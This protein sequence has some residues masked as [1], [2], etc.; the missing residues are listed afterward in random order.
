MNITEIRQKYPQ[1]NEI[2]DDE[3]AKKLH[4]K[5]YASMPFEEF[6][7]K[8]GLGTTAPTPPAP[9]VPSEQDSP[10]LGS[11]KSSYERMKGEGAL[12]A[13]KVGLMDEAEAEKYRA[14]QEKIAEQTYQP[15]TQG[16][17]EAPITKLK[18]LAGASLPYTAAP[19][20]AAGAAAL[21]PEAVIG[22]AGTA[23]IGGGASALQFTGTN[24]ARQM[25]ENKQTLHDTS[26]LKAGAAAVP[27]AALDIVGFK[28]MPLVRG[29]FGKAGIELSEQAAEEVAKRGILAQA[30]KYALNTG[31]VMGVEG[32]TEAG[33]QFFERLQ[34]GLSIAD[35]AA[36]QEYLESF[37]GGAALGG[38]FAVPGQAI[39]KVMA[40]KPE[41]KVPQKEI[42]PGKSMFD[43]QDEEDAGTVQPSVDTSFDVSALEEQK[44]KDTAKQ[45]F[46]DESR[47]AEEL[48]AATATTTLPETPTP[49]E[50]TQEQA[51]EE[52]R[53]YLFPMGAQTARDEAAQ[54]AYN[55]ANAELD[56]AIKSGNEADYNA[57]LDKVK[58]ARIEIDAVN[59]GKLGT[60]APLF[61]K[62][63]NDIYG[64]DRKFTTTGTD[65]EPWTYFGPGAEVNQRH[66]PGAP[67]KVKEVTR[68]KWGDTA[69]IVEID[70]SNHPEGLDENGNREDKKIGYYTDTELNRLNPPTP[71]QKPLF[72]QQQGLDLGAPTSERAQE[73]T[74]NKPTS[75]IGQQGLDFKQE[76][77]TAPV[78]ETKKEKPKFGISTAESIAPIQKFLATFKPRSTSEV[79]RGKQQAAL[80]GVRDESGKLKTSG[81]LDKIAELFEDT[82]PE[83]Q[84]YYSGVV[85]SFFDKYAKG[86]G[87]ASEKGDFENLN[88]LAPKDQHEV[89]KKHTN[90]P[91]LTTYEGAKKL[92]DAFDDHVAE[93]QLAGLG[94]TRASSG[95]TQ[96]DRVA[97]ILRKKPQAK[98]DESERAAYDYLSMFDLDSAL[99]AAAFDIATNTPRNQL[100][101][102]QGKEAADKFNEWLLFNAPNSVN[103]LF[104]QY[105]HG[106]KKQNEGFQAFES[107][108]ANKEAEQAY[109]S[110]YTKGPKAAEPVGEREVL[111]T[112]P[113]HPAAIYHIQNNDIN[114]ALKVIMFTS[115]S[116]FQRNLAKRL[117]EL[118]LPT[119]IGEDIVEKLA[120]DY[121]QNAYNLAMKMGDMA[122]DLLNIP[123]YK[124]DLDT[125]FHAHLTNA[126]LFKSLSDEVSSVRSVLKQNNITSG[127]IFDV[128]KDL[129][130]VANG[131]NTSFTSAGVYF[132]ISDAIS[133]NSNVQ[134]VSSRTFLHEVMHAATSNILNNA[135]VDPTSVTPKQ[136]AAVA[137]LE[138]LY[139]V[140]KTKAAADKMGW[141]G[142]TNMDEFI[143]EAFTNGKFQNYL[144]SIPYEQSKQS[145]WDKFVTYCLKLFG[146]DNVLSS[147]VANVNALF[148]AQTNKE[149]TVAPPLFA[150][151]NDGMFEGNSAERVRPFEI[152]NDLVKNNNKWDDVKDKF[153]DLMSTLNAQTRKHWLGAFTLRQMEEMI[154]KVY[155][156]NPE[157]GKKEFLPKIPQ[158]AKFLN[159]IEAMT[160][161]RA[162][163]IHEATTI[164]KELLNIQ[165]ANQPT[166]DKLTQ[167]IQTATV[168][169][170]DPTKPAPQ[171]VNPAS[172]TKEE[173]DRIKMHAM[174]KR[175]FDTLG[176]MPDGKAAQE[177]YRKMRDFF[178]KRLEEFKKIAYEREFA[179]L[180]YEAKLDKNDIDY[181]DQVEALKTTA[182][183]AIDSRFS[184]SIDPY[185]PLKRFGEFWVRYGKS[186]DENRKYMQFESAIARDKYL[187]E[188]RAD[189]AKKLKQQG[190]KPADI[191]KELNN[192][193]M[194][195]IG[196]QLHDLADDL[197]SDRKVFEEVQGIVSKAGGTT[198]TDP[199]ELRA[200]VLEQLGELYI[201][202]LPLQSIQRMF[203]HRQN[204]AGASTDLIRSFQHSA[205]HMAYQ[206]ARFKYA[207]RM[208]EQLLSAQGYVKSI[209]NA[210]QEAILNDYL[211]EINKKYRDNILR[212]PESNWLTNK[213]SN[214]N[215]LWYLTAP[216]SAIVNMMAV[217]SIALPVLGGRFGTKKS[218]KA[219]L[220]YMK[221]LSGSGWKEV[222]GEDDKG[223]PIY[224]GFD[225][226]SIGR[227][228]HL[229]DLQ[230]RAYKA[231]SESLLEQSLA[232]DAAALAE[233]PSMDYTGRW[234]KVMQIATFPFHKAER[235]NRE[236]T[237]MAA[238]DLAYEKNGGNFDAAVKEAS[239]L[240]WKTMFDYATY[241]KPRY[242]QGNVAK[243]LF[244]FKQYAQHMTYLLF[245][246]AY[247]STQN[248]SQKEYEALVSQY[249]E[250]TAKQ[251]AAE[252][253]S[254][255]ADARKTFALLMGM[256]FMFAGAMG[257][258]IWWLYAGI[259][260][261]FNAVFGNSEE[262]F[263]V[264]NDFKNKM[265]NVFGGFVGDSVSRGVIPQLTGASLSD[266]MST[267]ITDMWFRDV[268]KNQDEVQYAEN[269]LINLL[270]PTAGLFINSAEA[271]KRY[272][273]GNTERALEAIAPGAFK[274]LLAGS[275][276]ASEG[277]LTMKGD[278][279]ME[280]VSGK[281]AFLQMLGFTPEKLAQKQSAN[282]EAKSAEQAVLNR[283]QDLLNFLA[284]AIESEDEAAE[285]KVLA[286]IEDFNEANDWAAI[287][288]KTIR[289]SLKKRAKVRAE[290]EA[291]GGLRVNKKFA[292]L[293]EEKTAYANDEDEE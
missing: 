30:G 64:P 144:K 233:N 141:Y 26:L 31:K 175:E 135:K 32:A 215:F 196:N 134:A 167:I 261:A 275:R 202:T 276:L 59:S 212:P 258:P 264:E 53:K 106:Y 200:L 206:H 66:Y 56:A 25:D 182:Q 236:I 116:N 255:R 199:E 205:F 183:A 204:I 181:D 171:P 238:F 287:S 188:V 139:E 33:Q 117:V 243:V 290:S 9:V 289:Q 260:N 51:D 220:K 93:A 83:Q 127:A 48:K 21:A 54:N 228:P 173:L 12:L 92:S 119:T 263:D 162:K 247:E 102:G 279:L 38:V 252:T 94:I 222:I 19:L 108:E 136:K 85:D 159:S 219:I 110:S 1:Y 29:I 288:G 156:L 62:A 4:A 229:T 164:S 250:D 177:M 6:S 11:L 140:A 201:T 148:G 39:E 226:P 190:M 189:Y 50:Q 270:G 155:T 123:S 227:S 5:Y 239:D 96:M 118:N 28:A 113:L 73:V 84:Q 277:A 88:N 10:F 3:L 267:N 185:F 17:G 254:M 246:T 86:L 81:L 170:V 153:S 69:Y 178:K 40:K 194:I 268:K 13:G 172:P 63:E 168:N 157:T 161:E 232:H 99:R 150:K 207:P 291:F 74:T 293:A 292:D 68:D 154:G 286:K 146:Y 128:L 216:A 34:A 82:T 49:P 112:A 241:N 256:S 75:V 231:F 115:K 129:E 132:P 211:A 198:V 214:M 242:F 210:D 35:P 18:E 209:G 126:A 36:R 186:R 163:V 23:L 87:L 225:A 78:A 133:I 79:E 176:K 143:A 103:H 149:Y 71:T 60:Q 111:H 251:Y 253:N 180:Y 262:P 101:R 284:M 203:L 120:N 105:V 2:S 147:T 237:A 235:F 271:L 169:E 259:A 184:E 67:A 61:S 221:A 230:R 240:T 137:E 192:P 142:V 158:L 95:Y 244:A 265:N 273:D 145:L 274:N 15:I 160:S 130:N 107:I 121:T 124:N 55:Q 152:L 41:T 14:A 100:F 179:R 45:V 72:A 138:K 280:N 109:V 97:R 269:A 249:G 248:V 44:V 24:L 7:T 27:Q 278:T 166:V 197:F 191:E 42:T 187:A 20:A 91:D 245:R 234:G 70:T 43:I 213:L 114:A 174:L 90:L 217:P 266:R 272:N 195:K 125:V 257:L 208:D 89:L 165:R 8:I 47:K 80:F 283:R 151:R 57:A 104:N 37:I 223:N 76:A 131:V 58:Q 98:Y 52:F 77:P 46:E 16:W 285:E 281:D 218:S 122:N 282:I 193:A 22:A 224:G 65:G